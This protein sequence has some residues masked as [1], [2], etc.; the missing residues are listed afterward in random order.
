MKAQTHLRVRLPD[1]GKPWP[2]TMTTI[3]VIFDGGCGP[4]N[5][6]GLGYGSFKLDD[7]P[8]VHRHEFGRSPEMSNNVAEMRTAIEVLK[9]VVAKRDAMRIDLQLWGD[10]K[11]T[12]MCLAGKWRIK[13]PH[14][15][16]IGSEFQ[17]LAGKIGKLSLHWHPRE[18]S[19]A[20][21]GH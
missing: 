1:Y 11:L 13:S 20:V 10:S 8:F 6:G 19:V 3:R 14:L 9:W 12:V 2:G 18:E 15:K 16:P 21:L 7:D 4:E 5:P 17:A